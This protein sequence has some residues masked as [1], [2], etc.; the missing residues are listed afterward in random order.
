MAKKTFFR[1]SPCKTFTCA[2]HKAGFSYGEDGGRK[3]NPK[4][5]SFNAGLKSAKTAQKARTKRKK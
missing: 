5:P 1:G 4:S 3:P 2:G